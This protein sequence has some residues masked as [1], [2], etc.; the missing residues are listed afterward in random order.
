MQESITVFLNMPDKLSS[1]ISR[2]HG[3]ETELSDL[4]VFMQNTCTLW[5]RIVTTGSVACI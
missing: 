4:K 3:Y 1:L 2:S 5:A